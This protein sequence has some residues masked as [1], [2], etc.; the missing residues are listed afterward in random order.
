MSL[1]PPPPDPIQWHEGML[2]T[3][4]HFQQLWLRQDLLLHYHIARLSPFHYGVKRVE[5]DQAMLVVGVFR[6]LAL[7]A[8]LPDGLVLAHPLGGSEDLQ[9]DLQVHAQAIKDGPVMVH[10]VVP[11]Y[12]PGAAAGGELARY[13]SVEGAPVVDENTG[14]NEQP[15]ARL[16]PRLT[17]LVGNQVPQKYTAIPLA[18]VTYSREAFRLDD[19]MPPTVSTT[20]GSPL[21]GLCRDIGA[22]L[23]EKAAFL[24]TRFRAPGGSVQGAM[25][26]ETRH[27]VQC[28]VA[29]LP[30]LEAALAIGAAH[31]F[32]LHTVLC[33]IAGEVATLGPGLVPP[34]FDAYDHD[35]ILGSVRPVLDY[36][37]RMIDTVAETHVAVPF[38]AH[39]EGFRLTLSPAWC[40]GHGFLIGIRL[41]PGQGESE[42]ETW[43]QESAIASAKHLG[44][45]RQRRLRGAQRAGVE[46]DDRLGVVP[47]R[48]ILLYRIAEDPSLIEPGQP[49]EIA[50]PAPRPGVRRPA[51]ILL[52]VAPPV[53]RAGPPS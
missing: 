42:A 41:A 24:A 38:A 11:A 23:R 18:R 29:G 47:E 50:G 43:I 10:A 12:K 21:A 27:A 19:Y 51:E 5:I 30:R 25:L 16:R 45:L 34:Q 28:L 31:P 37:A 8:V 40:D 35:D 6:V 7:Q 9:I 15:M 2:L 17:L 22:R 4:Q 53:E 36:I 20:A 44:P 1:T 39:A 33:G 14:D 46:R 13:R 32:D 52:Y 49:L 48:G 26:A 3:P